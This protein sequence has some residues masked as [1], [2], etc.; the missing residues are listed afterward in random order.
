M[1]HSGVTDRKLVAEWLTD[2]CGPASL[3]GESRFWT[4]SDANGRPRVTIEMNGPNGW[5]G[6]RARDPRT[7]MPVRFQYLPGLEA[8][9]LGIKRGTR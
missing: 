2:Q 6:I 9:V 1:K 3:V 7:A 8:L 4:V 5:R